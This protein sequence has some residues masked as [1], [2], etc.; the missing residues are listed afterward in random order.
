MI[1]NK[2]S[3]LNYKNILQSEVT[4]SPKMN[5]F[6][7]NNGMGKTNLL[8]VIYYLSF[9]KSHLHTSDSQI[10]HKE[11][12]VCVIQGLYQYEERMEEIFCAI[13]PRQR[14]QFKRNKK[15]YDK[16]SEH[17][18]LLPLVMVSPADAS[19]IQGGSEE[20]RRFLD[21]II[22]Q[23]DKNYLHA[24]IQ[25]N[26]A[27]LQRNTLLKNQSLDTSLYEVLEM[28]LHRYGCQVYE[29][30][31]QL[32]E[33]LIPIFNSYYQTICRSTEEVG[34]S[35]LSPLANTDLS[36]Q[37]A[38]NRERDRI[39]GYT[40]VGIHKDELEMTLSHS[41]IRRVGSQG[42]NKTYLIALKLAQY[43][44]LA[45]RGTTTP[46]LLLDDI[47]DKLDA[48]RVEQIIKLVSESGFGQIFITD[49]N[50]KYLDEILAA[51][52]HDYALF[53][54]EQGEVQPLKSDTYEA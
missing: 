16:L 6:F 27:L 51:M 44:F 9:C 13:R 18:G 10:V 31:K 2:L 29:K 22:S 1:L 34:L 11:Q 46:I 36:D 47:F 48:D 54:V 37:L 8:D 35:Y 43:A 42:Q 40:S 49:T 7:G 38:A 41:L 21:L 5:C 4:F 15:E 23:Q 26:K 20:R 52:H 50:R 32:V 33:E 12:D 30:R 24:L 39:L 19:L 53:K 45:E 3:I 17:I 14:K 25:Y 28:Q